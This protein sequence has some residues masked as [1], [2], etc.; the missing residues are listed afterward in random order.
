MT[1]A[2]ITTKDIQLLAF[3]DIDPSQRLLIQIAARSALRQHC[4]TEEILP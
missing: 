1:I 3:A 4:R 2:K